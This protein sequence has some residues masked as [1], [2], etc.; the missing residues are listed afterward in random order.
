MTDE[1]KRQPEGGH[2]SG[3]LAIRLL[4]WT[5]ICALLGILLIGN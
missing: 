1:E 3:M 4:L 2:W 5:L